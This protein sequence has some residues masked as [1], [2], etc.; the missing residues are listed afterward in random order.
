MGKDATRTDHWRELDRAHHIHSFTDPKVILDQGARI[1]ARGDGVYVWDSDDRKILDGMAGLWCVNVG[2]GRKEL[3]NAASRQLDTLAYYNNH[4]QSATPA[5]IELGEKLA[6]LT[7]A[8]LD[9]FAFA[10]SGSEAN[11][12]VIRLVRRYWALKGAPTKRVIIGR[13]LGYHGST[14]AASSMGGMAPMHAMDHE[15]LPDFVHVD[16]PH[17]YTEGGALDL[18]AFGLKAAQSLE[19]KILEL[20]ADKVAAFIGEPIQGAGGVIEPPPNYWH[21]IERICRKHDVL[22][23]ADE[24][25]CGFGRTGEWFGTNLYQINPDV[26]VMAKGLSSGYVPIAAV[27]FNREIFGTIAKGGTLPHGYTY[28]GHPVSCAVALANLGVIER[29]SL[30]DRVREDVGP[31]LHACL[32]QTVAAHPLVGEIR[33]VGLM[34]GVQ[35]TAEKSSRALFPAEREASIRCR[36]HAYAGGLIVRAIGQAMVLS[37][38]LTITRQE[39]NELVSKLV[40]ALDA[41]AADLGVA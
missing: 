25:I 13:R 35:I 7:P 33:G 29:E 24:V 19:D 27:A 14:L 38:A 16:C 34:R 1:I 12:T 10:N 5:Q 6:T 4:F 30:V 22:L 3:I 18:E 21:A 36:E 31:Y 20:G 28:S 32:N 17:W 40:A 15:L 9:H 2:Y 23:I 26:M 11:D 8:G 37:P 39:I 41:T